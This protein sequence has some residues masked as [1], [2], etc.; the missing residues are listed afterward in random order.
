MMERMRVW[1]FTPPSNAGGYGMS[2]LPAGRHVW[3]LL[4]GCHQPNPDDPRDPCPVGNVSMEVVRGTGTVMSTEPQNVTSN[5]DS[6]RVQS[7]SIPESVEAVRIVLHRRDGAVRYEAAV[8]AAQ[9]GNFPQPEGSP[10]GTGFNFTLAS[11][12]S[13]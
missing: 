8:D 4:P 1:L 12:P 10:S 3:A 5:P 6:R 7:F 9:V 13:N 11:Y 2:T